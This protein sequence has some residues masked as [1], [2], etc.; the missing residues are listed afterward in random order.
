[1][2]EFTGVVFGIGKATVALGIN[3]LDQFSKIEGGN[4]L[5]GGELL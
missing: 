5:N 4:L 3:E 2:L 1:M